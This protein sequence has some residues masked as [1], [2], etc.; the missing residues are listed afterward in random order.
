MLE[1]RAIASKE[2]RGEDQ[3]AYRGGRCPA[4]SR[5]RPTDTGIV[6]LV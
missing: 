5:G 2:V 6:G 1:E 4:N 3:R